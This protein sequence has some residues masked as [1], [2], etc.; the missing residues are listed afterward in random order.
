MYLFYNTRFGGR[1]NKAIDYLEA[2]FYYIVLHHFLNSA[3]QLRRISSLI[4][5]SSAMCDCRQVL[6]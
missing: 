2:L 3:V 5:Y 1:Q 6:L 4:L